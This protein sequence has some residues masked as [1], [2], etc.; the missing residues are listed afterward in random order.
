MSNEPVSLISLN[1][2][3]RKNKEEEKHKN[4][5]NT[6]LTNLVLNTSNYNKKE[7]KGTFEELNVSIEII[8]ALKRINIYYPSVIQ[9]MIM[10][11]INM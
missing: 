2:M 1:K 6:E 11:K 5:D 10:K 4:V 9:Y 7:E 3:L 8:R